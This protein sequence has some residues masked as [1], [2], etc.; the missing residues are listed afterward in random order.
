MLA[1][2]QCDKKEWWR[3]R[4]ARPPRQATTLRPPLDPHASLGTPQVPHQKLRTLRLV[5]ARHVAL[6][7]ARMQNDWAFAQSQEMMT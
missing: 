7:T 5:A 2:K 1:C 3:P 4:I 6:M